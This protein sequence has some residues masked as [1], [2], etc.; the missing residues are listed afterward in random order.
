MEKK[1]YTNTKQYEIT[2]HLYVETNTYFF[3][4]QSDL[5]PVESCIFKIVKLCL[6]S[7]IYLLLDK[8]ILK[9]YLF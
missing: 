2:A 3:H 4:S 9:N 8:G 5:V 1:T 7:C 6:I